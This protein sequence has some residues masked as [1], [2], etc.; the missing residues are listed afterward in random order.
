M[1][2]DSG[3]IPFLRGKIQPANLAV[4]DVDQPELD[5]GVVAAGERIA[6]LLDLQPGFR[7]VHDRVYRDARLVDLL[8]GDH[9]ARGRRPVAAEAIE[10][11]L[12]DEFR[13]PVGCIRRM[14]GQAPLAAFIDR[15]DIGV[16]NK[17][18]PVA[19]RGDLRIDD[20]A[21]GQARHIPIRPAVKLTAQGQQHHVR[22]L[23]PDVVSDAGFTKA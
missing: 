4:A 14:C 11:F 17:E 3:D 2:I 8:E 12:R 5:P 9:L 18:H 21:A 16:P 10:L 1:P 19:V 7:L 6:V 13:E 23:G 15:P 20:A 22:L